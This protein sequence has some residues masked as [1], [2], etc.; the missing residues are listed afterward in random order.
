M[1]SKLTILAKNTPL[2]V[3]EDCSVQLELSNPLFNDVEMFSYPVALPVDGNR[4]VLKNIDDVN[5][6]VRP[7]S[8]EHMPIQILADGVPLAFGPAV[9]QET[10]V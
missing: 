7:M 10:N 8:Y 6:A 5:S 3:S 1:N 4:H 2:T 9:I